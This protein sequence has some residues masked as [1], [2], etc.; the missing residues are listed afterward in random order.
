MRLSPD[1]TDRDGPCMQKAPA[2]PAER[3]RPLPTRPTGAAPEFLAKG[4]Q[5]CSTSVSPS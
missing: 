2:M 4:V 3:E 5:R 1:E